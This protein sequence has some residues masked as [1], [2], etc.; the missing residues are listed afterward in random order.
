MLG[1]ESHCADD[2]DAY[3]SD[4]DELNTAKVTLM[5]NLSHYDSDALAKVNNHDN[6]D[7]N[8]MNQVVQ[9]MPSSEQSSVVN[10]SET[11]ITS[12]SNII[13][14]SHVNDTLTTELERYKEQVKVLKEGQKVDLKSKDNVSDSREQSVEIDRLQQTLSEQLKEKEYLMQTVNL[15][16][17]DFKKEESRNI[18]REIALE[19]K[20][21]QL[22]NIKARQLEP[23]LYDGNVIKN[24]SAIVITDSEETLMLA[25]ESRS[26][27]LLKQ[28]DPMI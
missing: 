13:P 21:K 14:Y 22:D 24:T 27:M 11:E 6:V 26:K 23:K 17:N 3:D 15:L 4:C 25:K 28:K 5:A 16:K 2:L 19:K 1:D 12:D 8:L 18:D 20:I 7:N 9:S 10:N